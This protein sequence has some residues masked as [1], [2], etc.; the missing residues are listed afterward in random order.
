MKVASWPS[1][2]DPVD[3]FADQDEPADLG[4]DDFRQAGGKL[5]PEAYERHARALSTLLDDLL[6]GRVPLDAAARRELDDRLNSLRISRKLTFDRRTPRPA[7]ATLVSDADLARLTADVLPAVGQEAPDRVL[8]PLT[9]ELDARRPEHALTLRVAIAAAC[10]LVAD[11]ERAEGGPGLD[12]GQTPFEMWSRRKPLPSPAERAAVRA[13]ER[14]PFT[15][16]HVVAVHPDGRLTLRELVGIAPTGQPD[17]P[18]RAVGVAAPLRP[19]RAGDTL[20]ARVVLGPDGWETRTPLAVPGGPPRVRVQSWVR[21]E[22]VRQRL[23][24][25]ALTV[26]ALLRRRGHVLSRRL[27]E[28]AWLHQDDDP[29][30]LPEL[31]DL[32]YRDHTEDLGWYRGL[33]A[34]AG[35]PVLELACGTG[36][37]TLALARAGVEV[38]GVDASEAMLRRLAQKLAAEPPDVRARV[39]VSR[40][41]F[42]TWRGADRYPLVLLPFNALH[43]CRDEAQLR[44]VFA[45]CAAATAPGGRLGFDAYLADA[46]LYDRDPDERVEPR[47]FVLPETGERIESWEQAWWDPDER[48]HH[49]LYVYERADGRRHRSH[50]QLR[51][52]DLDTLREAARAAGFEIEREASDFEGAPLGPDALKLVAVARRSG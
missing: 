6:A 25:R 9:D 36:R 34:R 45:T 10:F 33:A 18:V 22:L 5:A 1:P 37:L 52:F 21:L 40:G 16:W 50:L 51:M 35:G 49:V 2:P 20:L 27:V 38:H 47:T 29:Y 48:I 11:G 24:L 32:E 42:L 46:A 31:Y 8:G 19:L 28:W 41:D 4:Y 12:P 30:D 13:I 39:R 3:P 43:H 26:D 44:A 7:A 14:A 23:R 17:E 15:A